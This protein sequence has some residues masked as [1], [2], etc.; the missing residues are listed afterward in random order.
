[1]TLTDKS[2]TIIIHYGCSDFKSPKH[3]IYWIGA[4]YYIDGE[5]KYFFLNGEEEEELIRKFVEFIASMHSKTFVHWS[6]NKPNFGFMAIQNRYKEITGYDLNL[7]PKN[8]I[9][10]SEYLKEKYG[11]D[12]VSR[13]KGRLNNLA[14]L[15]RFSGHSSNIEVK[16]KHEGSQRIELIFSIYQAELQ[17]KLKVSTRINEYTNPYP[18]YFCSYGYE[19]FLEFIKH[20]KQEIILAP[21]SFIFDELK[22]DSL[23]TQGLTAINFFNFCISDLNI[24]M[25]SAVKFKSGFSR[26]KYLPTYNSIK[27]RYENVP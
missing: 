25:G 21:T 6:M 10:L 23:I 9:D 12:Y 5:K 17:G 1:M 19:I 16:T 8:Q 3:E 4:V 22:R 20:Q 27:K 26:E 14:E 7:T 15:N 13:D 11:V 2:N 18:K 24:N